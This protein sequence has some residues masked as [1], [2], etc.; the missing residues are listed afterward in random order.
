MDGLDYAFSLIAKKRYTAKELQDKLEKKGFNLKP[1]INRL[2]E[3]N[4]I[5]DLEYA[6]DY[7]NKKQNEGYGKYKILFQ[8]K[9]KGIGEEV[10]NSLEFS[11][12]KIEEIFLK[13]IQKIKG[14]NKKQKIYMFLVNRGFDSNDVKNLIY[15]YEDKL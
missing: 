4:Y 15:K 8:L 10:L 1:I 12:D 7:K 5:N 13:K 9:N 14:D 11:N 3:L 2:K 6:M